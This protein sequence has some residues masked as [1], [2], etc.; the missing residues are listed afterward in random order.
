MP[1]IPKREEELAR[2]RERRGG[3]RPPV[4][5]GVMKP[6]N[7]EQFVPD[8]DW[9][10]IARMVWDGALSSGQADYYQNSDLA[11]LYSICDDLSL[12]KKSGRRS[13]M[14]FSALMASMNVLLLTEGDRR[15]VRIELGEEPE[16][17]A[18][19]HVLGK[20]QYKDVASA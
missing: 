14:M 5:K 1:R 18:E 15:K 13:S 2:P 16:K 3:D 6:L 12:Y 4:T 11:I 17:K 9:H 20:S 8:E 7:V 19:L 10:P